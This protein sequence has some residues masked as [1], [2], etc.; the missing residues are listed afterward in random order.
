LQAVLDKEVKA[1][2]LLKED[3]KSA[4]GQAWKPDS[5]PA[6]VVAAKPT[7]A[8]VAVSQASTAAVAPPPPA[9]S[10]ASGIDAQGLKVRDLKS[11][12]ASKVFCSFVFLAK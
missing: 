10:L 8:E 3:Y 2:L 9:D 6:A 11:N 12:K 1:L 5:T 7:A 4:T